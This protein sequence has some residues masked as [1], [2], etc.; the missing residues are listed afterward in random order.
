MGGSWLFG[1]CDPFT[2]LQLSELGKI[3][4]LFLAVHDTIDDTAL[5]DGHGVVKYIAID[6][7]IGHQPQLRAGADPTTD[8][9]FNENIGHVHIPYDAAVASHAQ[10]SLSRGTI[11]A[12]IAIHL[13]IHVQATIEGQCALHPGAHADQRIDMGIFRTETWFCRQILGGRLGRP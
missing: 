6:A 2:V 11:G 9:S 3:P 10:N 5:L 1:S 8:A 12:H 4:G 7:A 13:T